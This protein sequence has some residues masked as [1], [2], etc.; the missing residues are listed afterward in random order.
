M[1]HGPQ[2]YLRDIVRKENSQ[3]KKTVVILLVLILIVFVT[4]V[5]AKKDVRVGD[6]IHIWTGPD[7]FTAG[8]PFYIE[9]GWS[10]VSSVD[11][12]VE[13]G[14][15]NFEL[16][17]DGIPV[18]VDFVEHKVIKGDPNTLRNLWIFNFPDGMT[19]K[20]TFTG[21]H[22]APCKSAV[23]AG[24]YEGPCANPTEIIYLSDQELV[25]T[26]S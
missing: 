6:Q 12:S 5:A 19:G 14:L 1:S 9:H 23:Q 26:I 4:P 17:V 15:F 8:E 11:H 3:M 20:H 2:L 22:S 21:L 24:Y 13:I 7:V 25:V 18:D 10:F 16:E